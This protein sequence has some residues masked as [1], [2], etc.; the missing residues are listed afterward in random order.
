MAT[1]KPFKGIHPQYNYA[2]E[3]VISLENLSLDE[4]KVIRQENPYSYVNMLVPKLDN[5]FL[6]GSKT[7]LVYKKINENLDDFISEGILVQD[8]KPSIYIYQIEENGVSQIGIW[9]LTSIDDYLNKVL[10]RHELTRP[11]RE[12]SLINYLQQTGID[13]NPVLITYQALPEIDLILSE[14]KAIKADLN[15]LN[16]NARHKLW[17]VDNESQTQS[18]ID[19]FADLPSTYIAD[20][21]HR[22]SAAALFGLKRRELNKQHQNNEEYNFFTSV[23]MSTDQLKINGFNRLIKNLNNLDLSN[24]L[25]QLLNYFELSKSEFMVI[26]SKIHEF[27]MYLSGEWYLL[28]AKVEIYDGASTID[29]LDV[30]ILQNYIFSNILNLSDPRTDPS[31]ACLSALLPIEELISKVDQGEYTVAF[32]LFPTSIDQLIRVADEGEVMPPKSTLIEPKFDVGLL[33]HKIN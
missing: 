11:D 28:R 22:A 14:I 21:H 7:A 32:T 1:I 25:N 5:L 8:S 19:A 26:P 10:K 29:E 9:T 6:L 2:G 13:A 24:F 23:Y 15:F 27:G 20:G 17:I 31:I 3:V 30:S 18:I 4:A 16:N 12:Q 33:I